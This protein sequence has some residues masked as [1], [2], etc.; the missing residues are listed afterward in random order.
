MVNTK[1]LP[2][3]SKADVAAHR[4]TPSEMWIIIGKFVYNVAAFVEEHP[5]GAQILQELAGK[6]ATHDYE[7]I[8]HSD[9]A[10][11]LLKEMQIGRLQENGIAMSQPN[12]S[13]V[14]PVNAHVSNINGGG[15]NSG[16]VVS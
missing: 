14:T 5:G 1:E 10:R 8:G 13:D 4:S 9:H 11:E 12:N 7:D 2:I 6:D 16:C 3:F 15:A